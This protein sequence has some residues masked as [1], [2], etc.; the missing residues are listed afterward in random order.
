MRQGS[1]VDNSFQG[2]LTDDI[3]PI[4]ESSNQFEMSGPNDKYGVDPQLE[5]DQ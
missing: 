4:Q 1:K 2:H 3:S 5:D